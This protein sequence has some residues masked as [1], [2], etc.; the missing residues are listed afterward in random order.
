MTKPTKQ[1]YASWFDT[2][3]YHILYKDRDYKEAQQFMDTLTQY[4]NLPEQASVLD[5]ACG[6]GR[7]SR[8]PDPKLGLEGCP[9]FEDAKKAGG[10]LPD[11]I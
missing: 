4:L 2:P 10:Q 9:L 7:H 8:S 5:L 1:W 6:K 11:G 3:Y